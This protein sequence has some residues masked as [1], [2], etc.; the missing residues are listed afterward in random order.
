MDKTLETYKTLLDRWLPGAGLTMTPTP[1]GQ[2][3]TLRW[4]GPGT[5]V[6]FV[7]EYKPHVA[8]QDIRVVAA[9]LERYLAAAE[10]TNGL[11]ARGLL[12]A[13]F[14]RTEQ[15]AELR[16]RGVNYVDLVGNAHLEAPGVFV[17]VEGKRPDTAQQVPPG[18][19][20]RGWV[21]TVLA[22]LVR[23]EL[24]PGPYRPIA[25][26]AGVALGT[27]N[28]C[29][30]N[31]EARAVTR[32]TVRGRILTNVPDLVALWV[33]TYG[34]V[35]RPR[36]RVRH[37]QM[38]E[39]EM[40]ARWERLDRVLAPRGVHWALTGADGAAA[41][42]DYFR[43]AETEIYADPAVFDDR[44]T[45]TALG[46]QPAVRQGN[47]RV[48][49]PPGPL[50]MPQNVTTVAAGGHVIDQPVSPLLL[51]YAELRLRRTEQANEAAEMLLPELLGL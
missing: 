36:L 43:A 7:V 29:M 33:Q 16:A 25:A 40:R 12:L 46:A 19:L 44:D 31:L 20:T 34:D 1:N 38:R 35:V 8:T 51:V 6:A 47:L 14:I 48:I 32:G 26:A 41:H 4:K 5:P 50:A 39:T 15:G 28:A 2:D 22:L 23:P 11:K 37:F 30:K 9:Q 24:R 10:G 3:A 17:H 45:L 42:R 13:P 21:K 18:R 27:V 49:E